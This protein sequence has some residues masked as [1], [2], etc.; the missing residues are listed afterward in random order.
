MK[1][2]RESVKRVHNSRA[3]TKKYQIQLST[4]SIIPVQKKNKY[5]LITN[6]TKGLVKLIRFQNGRVKALISGRHF[7]DF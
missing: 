7:E 3:V 2:N 6:Q 1:I 4:T 5:V